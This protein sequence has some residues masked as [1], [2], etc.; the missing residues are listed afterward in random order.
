M[1]KVYCKTFW[2]FDPQL[3]PE[4]LLQFS[5][6]NCKSSYLIVELKITMLGTHLTPQF[7]S[8][9]K[10]IKQEFQLNLKFLN[11]LKCPYWKFTFNFQLIC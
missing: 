5:I 6:N 10:Q 3:D 9:W 1:Q 7:T 4:L 11:C 2:N 8:I